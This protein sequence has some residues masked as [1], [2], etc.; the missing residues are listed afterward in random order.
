MVAWDGLGN[1]RY[2]RGTAFEVRRDGINL[3]IEAGEMQ[4]VKG[5]ESRIHDTR[6]RRYA[7]YAIP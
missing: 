1:G 7:L 6:R 3:A 2:R 5:R 4:G